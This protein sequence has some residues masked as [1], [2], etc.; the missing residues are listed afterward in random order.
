MHITSLSPLCSKYTH[1]RY[2]SSSI[3]DAWSKLGDM[4]KDEAMT[5]YVEEMDKTDENWRDSKSSKGGLGVGVSTMYR[6]EGDIW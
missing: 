2:V 5:K 1:L 6:N 4:S 3:R